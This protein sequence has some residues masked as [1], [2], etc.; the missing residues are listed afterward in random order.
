MKKKISLKSLNSFGLDVY[1]EDFYSIENLNDLFKILKTNP[2]NLFI[3]GGGTNILFTKDVD[4][5]VLHINLKGVEILNEN[6][7]FSEVKVS[8]GENWHDF[9][10]WSIEKNLGGLE[11]LS[12]IPGNVGTA[13]IQNIGAYGVELKDSFISCEAVNLLTLEIE[14]LTKIECKF[15]YRD[16]IFKSEKKGEYIIIN[17]TFK[18]TNKNHKI[19][20]SYGDLKKQLEK[21]NI[22]Y[23]T[24]KDI[25][26]AVTMIRKSKLPDPKILGNSGSFFKNPIIDKKTF[27]KILKQFPNIPRYEVSND[28]IKIPAGWLIEKAGFKG[29]KLKTCGVHENQALVLVN[30]GDA[31]GN[32]ILKLSELIQKS[33]N[34]IFGVKL[35][36]EV[37]VV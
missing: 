1:A 18:L 37:N 35:E 6:D 19:R 25:S 11:N 20:T 23:P 8:A 29:K 31:T 21:N 7:K 10:L 30:Y 2:P 36:R 14:T 13:P 26:E 15:G 4:G 5:I 33:I 24:I 17:V 27:S 3:L 22:K 12:L 9:V 16:S 32:E 28:E 34:T